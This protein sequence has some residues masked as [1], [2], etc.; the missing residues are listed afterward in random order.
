LD[1]FIVTAKYRAW[2]SYPSIGQRSPFTTQIDTLTWSVGNPDLKTGN[3]QETS[4]EFNILKRFVIEPFYGFDNSNIQQYLREENSKYFQSNVNADK[5]RIYGL[6]V[7][8]TYPLIKTLFWQN[9]MSLE[10]VRLSYKETDS[11]KTRF[12]LNSILY[13][14]IPKLDG[15][16]AAGIQKMITKNPTLQGYNTWGNDA[17]LCMIQKNFLNKRL[18]CSLIYVPPINFLQYSQDSYT[19]TPAYN[20]SSSAGVG[21]LKN[22]IMLQINYRFSS[23]KQVNIKKSSLDNETPEPTKKG[24]GIL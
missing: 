4:L 19:K 2:P 12:M 1:K 10:D 17:F 21:V 15:A 18:S 7:N 5:F 23:G 20:S 16:V 13:Y 22:I 14:S 8:F 24:G 6:R 11:R 9:W 3:Y